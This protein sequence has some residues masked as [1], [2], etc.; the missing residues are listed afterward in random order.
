MVREL[1]WVELLIGNKRRG[2]AEMIRWQEA[3][4]DDILATPAPSI[5]SHRTV[6]QREARIVGLLAEI[7]HLCGAADAT[8]RRLGWG[9]WPGK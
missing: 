6:V 2:L 9:P 1:R 4:V 8:H 3:L 5:Q 7:D